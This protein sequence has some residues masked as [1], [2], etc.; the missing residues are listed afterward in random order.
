MKII[1]SKQHIDFLKEK[2][3][4]LNDVGQFDKTWLVPGKGYKAV[5]KCLIEPYSAHYAG[6][7]LSSMGA[8]SYSRSPLQAGATIGRYCALGDGIRIMPPSHET[9]RLGM[10]YFDC[11]GQ[12]PYRSFEQDSGID[13]PKTPVSKEKNRV[14]VTIGDDVWIGYETV[15][16]RDIT[17]G[18]GAVIAARS[19]VTK[20]V[21]PYAIVAGAPATIKKYRFDEA[22]IARLLASRWTDYAYSSFIGMDTQDPNRFLDAFEPAT[23]RGE[24]QPYPRQPID[25]HAEFIR[26]AQEVASAKQ[27]SVLPKKARGL[28]RYLKMLAK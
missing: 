20:D 6:P 26:I 9:H 3:I 25:V 13:F 15:L 22:T 11:S 5:P 17:I 24:I 16:A 21:P 8:F 27:P 12:A 18:Q 4:F 2:R 1:V 10:S 28:R 19:I 14:N 23:Q 7:Y